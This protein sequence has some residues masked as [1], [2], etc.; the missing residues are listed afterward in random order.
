MSGFKFNPFTGELD[1]VG[2]ASG[3]PGPVVDEV[4]RLVAQFTT[5]A[6]TIVGNLVR[7]NGTNTVTKIL[8][9]SAGE[10][11]NGIFGVVRS[12]PNATTA[13]VIFIG[14]Q[15]GYSGFT[16]GDALFVQTDGTLGHTVPATG[17]VQEIGKAISPTEIFIQI[18]Q[19]LRRS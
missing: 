5:D 14:I 9:N 3:G 16:T 4:P 10:I 2:T 17:T 13:N 15:G 11:P 18:R 12:K 1:R 19:A 6:G 7:V 8:D